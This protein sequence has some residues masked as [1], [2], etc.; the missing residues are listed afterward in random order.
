MNYPVILNKVYIEA[1]IFS[2]LNISHPSLQQLRIINKTTL[3]ETYSENNTNAVYSLPIML[4][5]AIRVALNKNIQLKIQT[6]YYRAKSNF[7]HYIYSVSPN[8]TEIEEIKSFNLEKT[9]ETINLSFG[10]VYTL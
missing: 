1:G 10:L 7:E 9:I 4:D 3:K 5:A 2:G 8:G 6:S